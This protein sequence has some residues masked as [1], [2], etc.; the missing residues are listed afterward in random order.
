M[1][2][3]S[4]P[5]SRI[6]TN[7]NISRSPNFPSSWRSSRDRENLSSRAGLKLLAPWL[8]VKRS[9][10]EMCFMFDDAQTRLHAAKKKSICF[11]FLSESEKEF[12]SI[13]LFLKCW[14]IFVAFVACRAREKTIEIWKVLGRKIFFTSFQFSARLHRDQTEIPGQWKWFSFGDNFKLKRNFVAQKVIKI[15]V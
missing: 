7:K 13:F 10:Q 15:P 5:Q 12:P 6:K 8:S 14:A 4:H 3:A 1:L 2:L 9:F 11:L